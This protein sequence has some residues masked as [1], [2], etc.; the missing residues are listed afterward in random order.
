MSR[1]VVITGMGAISPY[2]RGIETLWEGLLSGK[3]AMQEIRH[4]DPAVYRSGYGGEV[5]RDV[6]QLAGERERPG[7]P[8][9]D[10]AFFVGLAVEE[11][12]SMAGVGPDFEDD[13]R[14]GCVL[15]TLCAGLRNLR[16]ICH[17]F[18]E[19]AVPSTAACTS[20]AS[21]QLDHLARRH[22]LT[23]PSSMV[24]TACSS[25]T[26]ALGYAFDLVR[27]G[28]CDACISGG[29]D[30][31][32]EMIHAA[33]NG[34][35]SITLS[36]PRPFDQSRD[37]FFIGEG[38]GAFYIETL[39]SAQARGA[40]IYAEIV[41]YGLSNTGYHLT[42]TSED[43]SGEALALLRALEDA[44]LRPDHIDFINCHG[45][46]TR[47][48]DGS[49]IR[50]INHVFGEHARNIHIT[51]NKASIGHCMGVAGA[52]EAASTAMTLD[53]QLI[54]PTAHSTGDEPELVSSLVTGQPLARPVRYALSQSFGFGGACSCIAL[55]RHDRQPGE[56]QHA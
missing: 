33:F 43:G 26:D 40:R 4:F 10:S 51:S 37:G 1:R 8:A 12:L 30:I 21:Y 36:Q 22:N 5:P 45:T 11:A 42:A 56:A 17:S 28:D 46:G 15:G 29:G 19:L 48:N 39:E 16:E 7:A 50:A 23:G 52:L 34:L 20:V 3:S 9:E 47:Y 31:L 44:N 49:E 13:D 38:A 2:G 18:E 55:A 35:Q 25:T 24:S 27:H 54:P 41:G 32:S 53:R 14:V 6:Y